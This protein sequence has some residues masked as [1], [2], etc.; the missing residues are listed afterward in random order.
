MEKSMLAGK[1]NIL[2]GILTDWK[3][4]LKRGLELLFWIEI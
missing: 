4:L 3:P 2:P 1:A